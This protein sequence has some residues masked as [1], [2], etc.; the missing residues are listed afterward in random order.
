MYEPYSLELT[1]LKS[2]ILDIIY[3]SISVIPNNEIIPPVVII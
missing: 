3:I 2:I 1:P